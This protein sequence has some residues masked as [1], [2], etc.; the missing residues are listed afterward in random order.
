KLG[1][2]LRE[3]SLLAEA[4]GDVDGAI[5]RYEAIVK[6]LDPKSRTALREIADL[7]EARNE[8]KGAAG[9]LERELV[10]TEG[11]P[12]EAP[13]PGRIEIAQRLA[14]LYEGELSDP[15]AAIKVLDIVH[16]ADPEDFD[17][18]GRLMKLCEQVEDWP[19]VAALLSSLIEVEGD[20]EEA[21][22]MTRRLADILNEK[23]GKGDEAL[24]AL[25]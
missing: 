11:N 4:L 16:E 20:E 19:R 8:L 13:D 22:E 1:H 6:Q 24:G 25:E 21:S 15:R 3:A 9:A 7:Q 2:A 18:V 5:E 17:A 23:I 10:L 12:G 14:R